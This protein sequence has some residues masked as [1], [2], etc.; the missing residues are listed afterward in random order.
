MTNLAYSTAA[1]PIDMY[2]HLFESTGWNVDYRLSK[3]ELESSLR[4]SFH[5]ISVYDEDRLVGFGRIVSDG[6]LHAMIYEMIVLPD[7]QNRGI[8]SEVLERLLQKCSEKKI[9]FNMKTLEK[10]S[11]TPFPPR[12]EGGNEII[13]GIVLK[14]PKELRST[15][16]S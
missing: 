13:A 15:R 4:N 2:F 9:A 8:G 16:V 10:G 5:F 14:Y 1:P 11:R 3:E 6:I 12:L 7:Y